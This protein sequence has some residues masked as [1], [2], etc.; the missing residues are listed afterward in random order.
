MVGDYLSDSKARRRSWEMG[1]LK[2]LESITEAYKAGERKKV[3]EEGE[4]SQRLQR[5]GRESREEEGVF[6][7]QS[8]TV[9]I[10]L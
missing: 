2:F 3:Y 10:V 1:S 5:K 4:Y 6:V 7:R 8:T 9:I